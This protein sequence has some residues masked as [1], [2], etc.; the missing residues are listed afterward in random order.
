MFRVSTIQGTNSWRRS[1]QA[2][3]DAQRIAPFGIDLGIDANDGPS[4]AASRRT[5]LPRGSPLS[6]GS[7]SSRRTTTCHSVVGAPLRRRRAR[8]MPAARRTERQRREEITEALGMRIV[9]H[10]RGEGFRGHLAA[11]GA[12]EMRPAQMYVAAIDDSE[13]DGSYASA[14]AAAHSRGGTVRQLRLAPMTPLAAKDFGALT[15]LRQAL[16]HYLTVHIPTAKICSRSNCRRP[17]PCFEG[18][19]WSLA[20][21]RHRTNWAAVRRPFR[22]YLPRTLCSCWAVASSPG[23]N[24]STRS[25]HRIAEAL[26]SFAK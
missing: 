20:R 9:V 19:P 5:S 25:K 1:E 13:Q 17:G 22:A 15:E 16:V 7:P 6:R 26:S 2:L 14:R 8:E 3:T 4:P 18:D 24:C 21:R 12:H 11:S 23:F 10:E